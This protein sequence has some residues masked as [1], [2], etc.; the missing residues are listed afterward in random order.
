M[1]EIIVK[2]IVDWEG[3]EDV[4]DEIIL[5]DAGMDQLKEGVSY[6]II[7]KGGDKC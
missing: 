1:K 6:E 5:S 4:Q 7:P 2:I 3:Y